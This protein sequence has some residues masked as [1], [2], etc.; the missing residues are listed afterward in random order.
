MYF[1]PSRAENFIHGR[2]RNKNIS[3][4]PGPRAELR[5]TA[6]PVTACGLLTSTLV[7]NPETSDHNPSGTFFGTCI[8]TYINIRICTYEYE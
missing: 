6:P 1:S 8:G 3:A 7:L 4:R 2:T 5:A